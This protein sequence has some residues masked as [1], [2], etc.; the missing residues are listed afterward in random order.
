[1]CLVKDSLARSWPW[2]LNFD[3][4]KGSII[5]T[6]ALIVGHPR[7]PREERSHRLTSTGG[8]VYHNAKEMPEKIWGSQ[9]YISQGEWEDY[10]G[11]QSS[12]VSFW[13]LMTR[14]LGLATMDPK[15]QMSILQQSVRVQWPF[16]FRGGGD[17]GSWFLGYKSI[18]RTI[19]S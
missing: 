8:R 6:A 2:N 16:I 13:T 11:L 10:C 1:M 18:G 5:V 19:Y 4:T 9:V 7:V 12:L 15:N 3:Q 14:T 17:K